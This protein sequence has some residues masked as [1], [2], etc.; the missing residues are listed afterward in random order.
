[1]I[2]AVLCTL[3]IAVA[4][5][6]QQ[7]DASSV[8]KEAALGASLANEA[9]RQTHSLESVSVQQCIANLGERLGAHMSDPN[10]TFS[11][12]VVA[13]LMSGPTHEA[14]AFPGG[15]IFV[16]ASLILE[17]QNEA[18]L[19]G[20]L[21]HSM[22]HVAERHGTRIA[23]GSPIINYGSVPLIFLGGWSPDTGAGVGAPLKFLQ[24]RREFELEADRDAVL[25]LHAAG[26]DPNALLRYIARVRPVRTGGL[27]TALPDRD[28]RL[29]SLELAIQGLP[30]AEYQE[31]AKFSGI[32]KEVASL[33]DAMRPSQPKRTRPPTLYRPDEKP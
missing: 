33:V 21:A 12:T 30:H 8:D 22:A 28:V 14:V 31:Q 32:Q 13:D 24:S 6:A 20:M 3:T 2:R 16:P 27:P 25:L 17:A 7:P 18:E 15:Y 5:L 9:R 26:Y 29:G 4:G 19:A 23:S 10:R 1:M 11:F